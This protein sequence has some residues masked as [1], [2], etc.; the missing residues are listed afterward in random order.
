MPFRTGFVWHERY[1]WHDTGHAALSAAPDEWIEP[2][3][4]VESPASK[5]RLRN[6]LD[7]SG[8]LEQLVAVVPR[9]ATEE[10]LT[11]VHDPQY[12]SRIAEMSEGAGGEGGALAPFGHGGYEIAC[13][14]AGGVIELFDA[15]LEGRVDNGYALVRPPGH[16]AEAALGMGF[17]LFNN[18]AVAVRHAHE[19]RNVDRIAI[20]DWDVHH[21]NGTQHAF[22]ADPATLFISL[23]QAGLFPP[24]SGSMDERGEGAGRGTTI[25]L[26]LPPGSGRGAYLAAFD[27]VVVPGIER[28]E[29]EL[30][31]VSS[32]FDSGGYDPLGRMMLSGRTYRAMTRR[33][34]DLA[35]RLGHGRVVMAHEGGY[36]TSHVPFCGVQVIEELSGLSSGLPDRFDAGLEALPYQ[37]LQLHQDSV[38]GAAERLLSDVPRGKVRT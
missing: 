35:A 3:E 26:P 8:L 28:F 20:V 12:V 31:V 27:R 22:A 36:S 2:E 11:R 33:L 23:H 32:G 9:P 24:G 4:H 14:A 6:L 18:V 10:E 34:L 13:L 5:R 17:C 1:A 38:I 19:A 29:P 7:V 16:H 25:N 30:I 37:D 21:G 15:V